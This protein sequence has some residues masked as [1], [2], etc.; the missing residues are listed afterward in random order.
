MIDGATKVNENLWLAGDAVIRIGA[1]LEAQKQFADLST[2]MIFTCMMVEM[3]NMLFV[4]AV[5]LILRTPYMHKPSWHLSRGKSR[6]KGDGQ[7]SI[8]NCSCC[9]DCTGH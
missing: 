5:N 7:Q 4:L 6:V 8:V 2:C 9:K 1:A 3:M